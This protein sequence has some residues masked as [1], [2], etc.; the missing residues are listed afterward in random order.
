MTARLRGRWAEVLGEEF[1][2]ERDTQRAVE[3]LRTML[4]EYPIEA[5]EMLRE[6]IDTSS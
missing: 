2:P 1:F 3:T 4:N 6:F 5:E